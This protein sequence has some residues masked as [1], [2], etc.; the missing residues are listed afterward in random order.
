MSPWAALA[1]L[2]L[3][4]GSGAFAALAVAPL[5]PS[6][7]DTLRLSRVQAGLFLPAAYLGGVLMSLPAGWLTDRLGVRRTLAGGLTVIASM[8]ALGAF[9]ARLDAFLACLVLAGFGFSVL[10]PAT[11]RAIIE[12]FAPRRRGAAMGIKQTG[13][14]LGGVAAALVLPAVAHVA[15]LRRALLVGA[16]TSLVSALIV[17][18]AYRE[19]VT[20]AAAPALPRPRLRDVGTFL[21]RPG[22]LVVFA[23][24]LALSIAQSSLLAYLALFAKETFGVSAVA[25]AH[26]LALAQLGGTASRLAGGVVSD[27]YFGSRRRPGVVLTAVLGAG[28][29]VAF[30]FGEALPFAL[31]RALAVVAGVGAFGWVGL[32]FALVAEVG[33]ARY[34]GVLTGVATM[35]AWSGVLV[36]PPVF[37]VLLELTQSYR[38]PWLALAVIALAVALTLPRPRP[39]VERAVSAAA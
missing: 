15:G 7:V 30:A 27:R 1:I 5:A 25:A 11:G 17:A 35:F 29:Y 26:L 12:W 4:H 24:G 31:V 33:G 14:T 37:G 9:A 36:G 34:A 32:Y 38:A 20:R 21:R 2:T 6:L 3:A 13:L 16:A 10:N 18:V 22:L 28:C 39:L 23:S 8:I 19:P